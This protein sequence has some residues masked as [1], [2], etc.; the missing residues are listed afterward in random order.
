MLP[1]PL[2]NHVTLVEQATLMELPIAKVKQLVRACLIRVT[3]RGPQLEI[4]ET[5]ALALL[6]CHLKYDWDMTLKMLR[7]PARA[8]PLPVKPFHSEKYS[9]LL[10]Q[11]WQRRHAKTLITCMTLLKTPKPKRT[12]SSTSWR[13]ARRSKNSASSSS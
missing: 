2:P 3:R 11:T 8:F 12:S 1:K 4:H 7:L 10:G 13:R 5:H 9:K 6:R